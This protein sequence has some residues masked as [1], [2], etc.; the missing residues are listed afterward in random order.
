MTSI[1]MKACSADT[2]RW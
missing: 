1:V 2:L